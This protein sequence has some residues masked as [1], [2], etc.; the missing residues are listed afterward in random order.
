MI[1]VYGDA[2]LDLTYQVNTPRFAPEDPT[3]PVWVRHGA[4][5]RS[6]G[7]AANVAHRVGSLGVKAYLF[8]PSAATP[9]MPHGEFYGDRLTVKT[10]WYCGQKL[11]FRLDEDVTPLVADIDITLLRC[12]LAVRKMRPEAIII[13]DYGKGAV[14]SFVVDRLVAAAKEVDAVVLADPK[15]RVLGKYDGVDWLTPNAE[16]AMLLGLVKDKRF[17][18]NVRNIVFKA[19]PAPVTYM[20]N[21]GTSIIEVPPCEVLDPTGAGDS[22]IAGLAVGLVQGLHP[23]QAIRAAI[24]NAQAACKIM[25]V[26]D[27]G[28]Q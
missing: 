17:I 23:M 7:G 16:E 6:A 20:S 25:G 12:E 21:A 4:A 14:T 8:A 3:V 26:Y 10:R 19:G 5:V 15:G 2:M 9:E 28:A 18:P 27:A 1:I 11:V 13:S 24:T 22:F